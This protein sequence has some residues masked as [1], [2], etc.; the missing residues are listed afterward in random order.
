M[1]ALSR[2]MLSEKSW[3]TFSSKVGKPNARGCMLW[4]GASFSDGYGAFC[5]IVSGVKRTV[6]VHRL[7][8]VLA[9]GD[10]AADDLVQHSC[11]TPLCCEPSHLSRGT[12]LSNMQDKN[13]KGRGRYVGSPIISDED[14]SAI[15]A[16]NRVQRV[17]AKEFGIS[18]GHVSDIKRGKY[19]A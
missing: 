12:P 13:R 5:T 10:L 16:D 14:V 7:A 8:F 4:L 15:R 9:H 1:S 6:R 19:R 17:I 18:Q 3:A 11:D 2:H